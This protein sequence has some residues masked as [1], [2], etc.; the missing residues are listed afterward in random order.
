MRPTGLS[1]PR[2]PYAEILR[3][4]RFFAAAQSGDL[5]E[6]EAVLAHDVVLTGDGGGKDKPAEKRVTVPGIPNGQPVKG[7][8]TVPPSV[9]VTKSGDGKPPVVAKPNRRIVIM[10]ADEESQE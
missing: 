8:L 3:R 1:Q 6:L 7:R 5:A 10:P 4:Q 2:Q 9:P